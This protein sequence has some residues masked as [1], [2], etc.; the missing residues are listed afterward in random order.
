MLIEIEEGVHQGIIDM[1]RLDD[2][3]RV[4]TSEYDIRIWPKN[5][6]DD[7]PVQ[8]QD[9]IDPTEGLYNSLVTRLLNGEHIGIE[10][11]RQSSEV[12]RVK[13]IP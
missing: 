3:V 9:D 8:V 5:S 12:D 6:R 4:L 7:F 10:G 13:V 1:R 2:H 11:L